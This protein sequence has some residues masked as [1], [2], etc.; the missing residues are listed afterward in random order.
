M[1]TFGSDN[2]SEMRGTTIAGRWREGGKEG[3][4]DEGGRERGREERPGK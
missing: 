1:H 4:T 2:G 3:G